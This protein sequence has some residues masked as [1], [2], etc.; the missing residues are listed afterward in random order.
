MPTIY[1][2]IMVGGNLNAAVD[3]KKTVT[4]SWLVIATLDWRALG[5][6]RWAVDRLGAR[7]FN[8]L[9]KRKPK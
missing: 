5:R 2:G 8:Q 4:A 9:N 1:R 7:G 3:S 6:L